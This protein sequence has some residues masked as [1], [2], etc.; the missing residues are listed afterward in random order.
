MDSPHSNETTSLTE[1]ALAAGG[2]RATMSPGRF[3]VRA[4]HDGAR[5]GVATR[6]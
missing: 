5:S 1:P 2:S 3:A 4:P 6:R